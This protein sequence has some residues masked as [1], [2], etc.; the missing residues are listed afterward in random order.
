MSSHFVHKLPML[1]LLFEQMFNLCSA[2]SEAGVTL[3]FKCVDQ[4]NPAGTLKA[5]YIK[6]FFDKAVK[7]RNTFVLSKLAF[8]QTD[9]KNVLLRT[10]NMAYN[11]LD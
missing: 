7:A 6:S 11:L 1:D 10:F 4:M 2:D 5:A 9:I 8:S 3:M